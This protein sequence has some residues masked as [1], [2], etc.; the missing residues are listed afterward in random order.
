MREIQSVVFTVPLSAI[1]RV[2]EIE[3]SHALPVCLIPC[4]V[5]TAACMLMLLCVSS[6][7]IGFHGIISQILVTGKIKKQIIPL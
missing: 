1:R 2:R 4:C 7:G 3:T 6:L 5:Q